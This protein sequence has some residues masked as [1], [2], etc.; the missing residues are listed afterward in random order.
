MNSEE[1]K[2]VVDGCIENIKKVLESKSQEY[3]SKDDK[4]HNFVEAA[5]IMR[6]KTKEFALLGMLNKHLVSIIDMV[7]KY[8]K[9]GILP[10][11]NIVEEKIG[12]GTN[13]FILLKACFLEDICAQKEKTT[14]N[15]KSQ[16]IGVLEKDIKNETATNN[17][18][19]Q[20]VVNE[21]KI[22]LKPILDFCIAIHSPVIKRFEIEFET[23]IKKD[24]SIT[25]KKFY[26]S[27]ID[28][29]K[30]LR[31]PQDGVFPMY[32]FKTLEE[33]KRDIITNLNEKLERM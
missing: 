4:L 10:D 5:K 6:C 33:I 31:V 1:F 7:E 17:K 3:S 27:I 22:L 24:D 16:G 15:G 12:D 2:K 14:R 18:R 26:N 8:E 32:K 20:V 29:L 23:E 28:I 30:E 19:K 11:E 13:Y 25:D 21:M 9:Y